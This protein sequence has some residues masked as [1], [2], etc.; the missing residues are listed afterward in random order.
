MTCC[1]GKS[2]EGWEGRGRLGGQAGRRGV[3]GKLVKFEDHRRLQAS[4]LNA[5]SLSL[6]DL[7]A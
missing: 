5:T 7:L 1:H 3:G 6:N 4:D 2:G